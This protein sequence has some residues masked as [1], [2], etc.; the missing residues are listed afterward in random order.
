[1]GTVRASHE[2]HHQPAPPII[3]QFHVILRLIGCVTLLRSIVS[4]VVLLLQENLLVVLAKDA[5]S[6]KQ[7]VDHEELAG[8]EEIP[9]NYEE[10]ANLYIAAICCIMLHAQYNY[11]CK[12]LIIKWGERTLKDGFA[13]W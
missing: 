8:S 5:N 4:C 7:R 10:S 2:A 12:L 6:P 3:K 11:D 1:M 13:I 9:S